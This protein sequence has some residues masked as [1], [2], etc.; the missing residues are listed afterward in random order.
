MKLSLIVAYAQN[1]AIGIANALPWR[2]PADLQHFKRTTMGRPVIMGRKTWD[3]IGRPLP[4]RRNI[5]VTRNADWQAAGA[6]RVSSI[7]E[8]ITACEGLDEAFVIGGAQIYAAALPFADAVVATEIDVV[9]AGDTFF[10][11][12]DLREWIEVS[13]EDHDAVADGPDPD[14]PG[15]AAPA[16]AWVH[17]ARRAAPA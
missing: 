4:G 16:F 1:R 14:A 12:L 5:V 7:A 11:I 6:E 2:L 10:E 15:P 3:S 13:R 9:V 17:Y 8:A